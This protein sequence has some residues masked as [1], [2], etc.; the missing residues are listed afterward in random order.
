M[1]QSVKCC[2][3]STGSK[4]GFL[5]SHLLVLFWLDKE[6]MIS[7]KIGKILKIMKNKIKIPHYPITQRPLPQMFS[8]FLTLVLMREGPVSLQIFLRIGGSGAG[9]DFFFLILKLQALLGYTH[10]HYKFIY[11]IGIC[12][13]R[14]YIFTCVYHIIYT[15]IIHTHIIYKYLSCISY[16]HN[17][18]I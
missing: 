10:T 3:L 6:Y 15:Y 1:P 5:K 18:T 9:V 4:E 11:I 8:C 17:S 13:I 7:L 16:C 2:L 14:I 12:F